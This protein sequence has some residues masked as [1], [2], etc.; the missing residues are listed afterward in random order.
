MVM[1]P[2]RKRVNPNSLNRGCCPACQPALCFFSQLFVHVSILRWWWL[3]TSPLNARNQAS[4]CVE[5]RPEDIL[6]RIS[7]PDRRVLL[8]FYSQ[9]LKEHFKFK[10]SNQA[11]FLKGSISF[12]P[13]HNTIY[14]PPPCVITGIRLFHFIQYEVGEMQATVQSTFLEYTAVCVRACLHMCTLTHVHTCGCIG[15]HMHM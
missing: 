4:Y 13:I 3:C 15:Q 9:V 6:L 14:P 2:Q 1:P 5:A 8:L 11:A 7:Y 10:G 12:H